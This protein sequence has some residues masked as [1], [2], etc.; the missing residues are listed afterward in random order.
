MPTVEDLGKKVKAKY[1][2]QYDDLPDVAVGQ[3]VKAKFKGSYDDF[4][5]VAP[6]QQDVFE[7]AVNYQTGNALVD[8]PLGVLQGMAKGAAS[9][10]VGIG[11]LYRKATGQ[12]PL[13]ADT[14]A[15][16]TTPSGPGQGTGKFIEQTAEFVA[17]AGL[18]GKATKGLGLLARA[19]GQ[20]AVGAGVSAA[21]TGGD[22]ASIAIGGALGG[23]GEAAGAVVKGAKGL[24]A[25]KA[26]TLRNFAES[27][28][29]TPTQQA[30]ITRA[31][32]TLKNDGI[33]PPDDIHATQDVIHSQIDKLSQ[34]YQQLPPDIAN[35]ADDA[36]R[37]MG[38]LEKVQNKFL[39]SNGHI[40]SENREAYD[41]VGRQIND[42]ATAANQGDGKV[43]FQ[44]LK[45]L[46]DAVNNKTNFASPKAEK[47][48]YKQVGDVYRDALDKVAPETSKLNDDW[49][50]YRELKDIVDENISRGKG[51]T[52]GL[53][54]LEHRLGARGVGAAVGGAIGSVFGPVGAATGAAAGGFFGPKIAKATAQAL[55]NAVDSGKLQALPQTKQVALR[56]AVQIGDN[57]SILKLLGT[58]TA[59]ESAVSTTR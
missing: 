15:A 6:K 57:A 18:V 14:F 29:A 17:P 47:D 41:R 56:M 28:K 55:Q 32:S 53:D 25:E 40:L 22:P 11:A 48:L 36:L 2:G 44:T 39:T 46:R 37:V 50:R 31:L 13:P 34:A 3:K 45:D 26:P 23:A 52:S 42:V 51:N 49:A 1:P 4:T 43:S 33:I 24:L 59:E 21:Q 35:R 9:T 10:G 16:D 5:D 8:T 54:K 20:A 7:K 27:F 12:S 58:S 19:G 38:E 30:K